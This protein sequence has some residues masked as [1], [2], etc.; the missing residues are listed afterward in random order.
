[1]HY[2]SAGVSCIAASAGPD[3]K[4][5]PKATEEPGAMCDV[6]RQR[7]NPVVVAN[8]PDIKADHTT[9]GHEPERAGLVKILLRDGRSV[10]INERGFPLGVMGGSPYSLMPAVPHGNAEQTAGKEL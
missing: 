6:C 9:N 1:M 7:M 10:A 2:C 4:V 3:G 5:R 8:E